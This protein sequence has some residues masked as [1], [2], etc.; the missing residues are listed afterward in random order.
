MRSRKPNFKLAASEIG[1]LLKYDTTV[2]SINRVGS[3]VFP[4]SKETFPV[5]GA[6]SVRATLIYEWMMSLF[7]FDGSDS[8]K[9][10]M[11]I[12]FLT[13][14]TPEDLREK[15]FKILSDCGFVD[16]VSDDNKIFYSRAF[17]GEVI[18][19]SRELFLQG[20]YFYAVFE[21]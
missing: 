14:I 7:K 10:D 1:D 3:S 8:D 15:V 16:T 12:Q 4:F 19:H 6:T 17:H 21:S 11:L 5:E 18:K 2:N 20:S 13:N 9:L